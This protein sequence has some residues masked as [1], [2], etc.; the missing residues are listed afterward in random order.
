[1]EIEF[2]K[3]EDVPE[4]VELLKRSLGESL[5]PKTTEYF[6][7]KHYKNPFGKSIILIAKE[8]GKIIGLRAF[9]KWEWVF[10]EKKMLSVRAVDT[11]TDPIYHGRGI[12]KKLTMKAI[13]ESQ[14]EQ[15]SF[16]YNTPNPISLK[17]YLTLGWHSIGK[18]PLSIRIGSILPRL[19]NLKAIELFYQEYKIDDQLKKI[20]RGWTY[21]QTDCISSELSIQYLAWRYADCPVAKY[22]AFISP[23]KF[24]IIF[25]LK[26]INLF[27][28]FRICEIWIE[29][30]LYKK[31]ME[32]EINTIIKKIRPIIVTKSF[33]T[34]D[35]TNSVSFKSKW[36]KFAWG[37]LT[38]VRSVV[39]NGI[40]D[41]IIQF[42]TWSP[43]MGTM[44]LF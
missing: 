29:N 20:K 30:H 19:Y 10:S 8:E 5:M 17:G 24:G 42:N 12:F 38:T 27:Y 1:M 35:Q 18:L 4:I 34:S 26:K 13:E 9:M 41:D 39:Q 36:R 32:Q 25:R 15:V 33:L 37:P 44:E 31:E 23:E 6:I 11:A 21:R 22:G 43:S 2:S 14:K 16:I 40:I 7:W 28:E 3:M